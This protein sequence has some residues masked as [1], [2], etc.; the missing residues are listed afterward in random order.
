MGQPHKRSIVSC[1]CLAKSSWDWPHYRDTTL[2]RDPASNGLM[3]LQMHSHQHTQ[4]RLSSQ[5]DLCPPLSA[6]SSF[7]PSAA[8]VGLGECVLDLDLDCLSECCERSDSLSEPD[9]APLW[10]DSP[11]CDLSSSDP[12]ASAADSAAAAAC[13]VCSRNASNCFSISSAAD[14]L[15]PAPPETQIYH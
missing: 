9:S 4:I 14:V 12:A 8:V 2:D 13:A 3:E 5:N 1:G 6:V 11:L 7:L 10:S 15:P